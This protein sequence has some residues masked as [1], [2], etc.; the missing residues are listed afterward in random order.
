MKKILSALVVLGMF[1]S[2]TAF[3][4]TSDAVATFEADKTTVKVGEE[5]TFAI[6]ISA[7][8]NGAVISGAALTLTYDSTMMEID[9]ANG[10]YGTVTNYT[11]SQRIAVSGT[12]ETKT[13]MLQNNGSAA[14]GDVFVSGAQTLFTFKAKALKEGS[15]TFGK[16]GTPAITVCDPVRTTD[17]YRA[18]FASFPT[19]A[20]VGDDPTPSK[21]VIT[22]DPSN[23][24]TGENNG[25]VDINTNAETGA[26]SVKVTAPIGKKAVI[27]IDGE[28]QT[29][30]EIAGTATKDITIKVAYEDVTDE[31]ITYVVPMSSIYGEKDG[32]VAF[33]KGTIAEGDDF[34]IIFGGIKEEK[35]KLSAKERT[36][37]GAVT[38][39]FGVEVQEAT[40]GKYTAQAYIGA[41]V[42]E[43]ISFTK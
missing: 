41:N 36:T 23:P 35:V 27:Y 3:A 25:I 7:D 6:K 34:G 43:E 28:A 24:V 29:G 20:I 2:T 12:G 14:K 13:L 40:A 4:L 15:F 30:S 37:E 22:L 5:V 39:I 11:G 19:V 17:T 21:P 38:D 8:S 9:P 16:R 18:T 10:T 42:G 31:V 26:Y 33:G 1:L 32:I